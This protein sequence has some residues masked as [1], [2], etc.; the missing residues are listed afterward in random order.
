MDGMGPLL[1]WPAR[2]CLQSLEQRSVE[3]DRA[4]T[5]PLGL[6]PI[7]DSIRDCPGL[8]FFCNGRG[9]G[10]KLQLDSSGCCRRGDACNLLG[11]THFSQFATCRPNERWHLGLLRLKEALGLRDGRKH[12]ISLCVE[13]PETT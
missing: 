9:Q 2:I 6:R 8:V 4:S 7:P 1:K 3:M 10:S 13:A 11:V 5:W 12:T